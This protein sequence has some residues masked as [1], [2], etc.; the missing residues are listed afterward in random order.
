LSPNIHIENLNIAQ[1]NVGRLVVRIEQKNVLDAAK[2]DLESGQK[3]F[4]QESVHTNKKESLHKL[5]K[6]KKLDILRFTNGSLL[7]TEGR[8]NVNFAAKQKVESIGLTKTISTLEKLESGFNYAL[9]AIIT[10]TIDPHYCSVIIKR[11][12]TFTGNKAHKET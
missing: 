2:L 9:N 4:A 12:E 10:T 7:I 5:L 1:K 8:S 6:V 11:W 3:S